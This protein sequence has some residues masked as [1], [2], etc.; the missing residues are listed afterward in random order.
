MVRD[1]RGYVTLLLLVLI[2]F[3]FLLSGGL[4][5]RI[6]P[7]TST[8]TGRYVLA[9]PPALIP[10]QTL[11]LGNLNF[12]FSAPP[13][14]CDPGSD[15]GDEPGILYA[16]LPGCS[17]TVPANGI[18][19]VWYTDE[20]ALTLGKGP[21]VS[22]MPAN[23]MLQ[24]PQVGDK[25]AR[26]SGNF[27]YYPSLF[28]TDITDDPTLK[29]GD[30]PTSGASGIPPSAVF[31][32][33][34][35][36]GEDDPNGSGFETLPTGADQFSSIPSVD[37]NTRTGERGTEEGFQAEILWNVSSLGLLPGHS[38]RAQFVIHDGDREGDIGLGCTTIIMSN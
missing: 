10:H 2:G 38:Y 33:W 15:Y 5:S 34:K 32:T 14:L 28:L 23:R 11:Q 35:A 3:G 17:E 6:Q 29:T 1:E 9:D 7:T 37:L 36:L 30:A 16:F 13:A 24:N 20:H 22:A 4:I 31:G 18:I 21:G 19:K 8:G 25:T 12:I 27:Q 26:D